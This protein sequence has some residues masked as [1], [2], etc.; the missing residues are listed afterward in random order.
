MTLTDATISC[1]RFYSMMK[2]DISDHAVQNTAKL[3]LYFC[4]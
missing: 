1:S 3:V 4:S 2:L